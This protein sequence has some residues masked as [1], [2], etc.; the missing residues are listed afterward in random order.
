MTVYGPSGCETISYR[1]CIRHT[2]CAPG[3]QRH[4]ECRQIVI[5][6][7]LPRSTFPRQHAAIS[8]H[9]TGVQAEM[10]RKHC[11]VCDALRKPTK[12][13]SIAERKVGVQVHC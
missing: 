5:G 13:V 8:G 6:T 9:R 11:A 12:L 10:I 7:L 3:R 1:N 4:T 2:P